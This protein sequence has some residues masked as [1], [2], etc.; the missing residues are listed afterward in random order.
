MSIVCHGLPWPKGNITD[1]ILIDQTD[2]LIVLA[3]MAALL[4]VMMGGRLLYIIG[5]ATTRKG[6]HIHRF[7]VVSNLLLVWFMSD[8]IN[9]P[10]VSPN[11]S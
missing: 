2:G 7:R 8:W 11:S 3:T 1:I 9:S 4:V 5:G 10:V 6:I